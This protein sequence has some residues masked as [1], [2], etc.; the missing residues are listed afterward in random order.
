MSTAFSQEPT[1]RCTTCDGANTSFLSLHD[2]GMVYL[3]SDCTVAF[4]GPSPGEGQQPTAE[5]FQ[6]AEDWNHNV[7]TSHKII[8]RMVVALIVLG[9]AVMV[10]QAFTGK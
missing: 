5:D 4:Y 7:P 10:F 8:S 3:C 2:D 6:Q 9:L 1:P